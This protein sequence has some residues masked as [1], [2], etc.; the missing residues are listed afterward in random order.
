MP[1][2]FDLLVMSAR[3]VA[4]S[5]AGMSPDAAEQQQAT[6]TMDNNDSLEND[7]MSRARQTSVEADKEAPTY[8]PQLQL[9]ARP[10]VRSRRY[11]L[12]S[13]VRPRQMFNDGRLAINSPLEPRPSPA[14]SNDAGETPG[15]LTE[16]TARL[17]MVR[18]HTD[19]PFEEASDSS[20]LAVTRAPGI[21]PKERTRRTSETDTQDEQFVESVRQ[22]YDSIWDR[23]QS[24][25]RKGS[26][27]GAGAG[28]SAVNS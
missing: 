11:S 2:R 1:G 6:T 4:L 28:G 21:V 8:Q 23:K 19:A 5:D 13:W 10:R 25:D 14:L 20:Q 3:N 17:S 24:G 12:D 18:E 16:L 22:R 7:S 26:G 27:P 15:N 9:H